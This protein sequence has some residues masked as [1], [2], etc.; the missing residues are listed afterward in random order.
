MR[1]VAFLPAS[2][3]A[4][5]LALL[6]AA[7]ACAKML[8]SIDQ[9]TQHM[10]VS[11][12]GEVRY[13]WPVSTGRAGYGTPNGTFRPNRMEVSHFSQVFDNAPMPH[14]IFFTQAGHAIHGSLE[15]RY[16]GSAASH[17]CVRLS[18]A[19]ATTLYA[20][21]KAEGMANTTVAI[22]GRI[23]AGPIIAR[24][25]GSEDDSAG[26][27][28][29]QIA[30]YEEQQQAYD[31]Q[32]SYYARSQGNFPPQPPPYYVRQPAYGQQQYYGQPVYQQPQYYRPY[33]PY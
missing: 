26:Y 22:A 16:L 18:P 19:N 6:S 27:A 7:P 1:F 14:S 23:P 20:L 24:R 21:V 13:S 4:A 9:S 31:G 10:T 15:V 12:D 25:G 5:T 3:L 28:P 2:L 33:N 30:P 29:T 17:G 8:I 11:V 32:Q